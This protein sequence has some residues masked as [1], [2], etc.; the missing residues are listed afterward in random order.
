MRGA[1]YNTN[2]CLSR[3][4][5]APEAGHGR[6]DAHARDAAAGQL[7]ADAVRH[8]AREADALGVQRHRELVERPAAPGGANQGC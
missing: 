2:G 8:A 4:E 6:R 7:G 5:L 3:G 1:G